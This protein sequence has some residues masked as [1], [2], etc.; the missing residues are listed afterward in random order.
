MPTSQ[1]VQQIPSSLAATFIPQF[2]EQQAYKQMGSSE[3]SQAWEFAVS[4]KHCVSSSSSL[5]SLWKL[6]RGGC[7]GPSLCAGD[8]ASGLGHPR[9]GSVSPSAH[10]QR[11][12]SQSWQPSPV[13]GWCFSPA[14]AVLSSLEYCPPKEEF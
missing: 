1:P 14:K 2:R 8:A 11:K 12:G 7:C 10:V 3:G 4:L 6:R 5:L 13:A 9:P